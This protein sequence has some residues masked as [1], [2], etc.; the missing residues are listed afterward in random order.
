MGSG[1]LLI[2]LGSFGTAAALN[3]LAD[4]TPPKVRRAEIR[5]KQ[6]KRT[7]RR[8]RSTGYYVYVEAWD[9]P[10]E[11]IRFP[12]S[13]GDYQRVMPGKSRLELTTGDGWLGIPWVKSQQ[14]QP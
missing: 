9:S 14:V 11:M 13:F 5:E 6:T 7:G 12:V 8:G 2:G 4:P 10:G 3:A 1:V